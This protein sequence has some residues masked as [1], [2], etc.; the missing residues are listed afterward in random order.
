MSDL[1]IAGEFAALRAANL[2][3]QAE[4]NPKGVPLGASFAAL[5]LAGEVGELC[6]LIKKR[7]RLE[8]GI[9]AGSNDPEA[10]AAELADVVICAD[11]LAIALGLDLW[12][13]V[14]AKFNATSEAKGFATRLVGPS[15]DS[16]P[17]A[18]ARIKDGVDTL[19]RECISRLCDVLFL[20]CVFRSEQEAATQI[21]A[22]KARIEGSWK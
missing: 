10:I 22:I 5:E 1:P 12:P 17:V 11:L 8:A 14:Q 20:R 19:A 3:R 6:N 16:K 4:F 7:A 15:S 21:E 2:A 9:A 13:I 18:A